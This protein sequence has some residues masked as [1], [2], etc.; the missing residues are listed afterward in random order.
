MKKVLLLLFVLVF[1]A[2]ILY[3]PALAKE[4]T[5]NE[6]KAEAEANRSAYNKAKEQKELSEKERNEAVAEKTRVEE[7]IGRIEIELK[8]IEKQ[9]EKIQ[10]DIEK[11][12]KQMKEIMSFVQVSNGESNYMEYIF[13]ATDFTD[14]IYRVSVAEQLEDYNKKLID[15]YNENIKKLNTKQTELNNKTAELNKKREELS[16]LEAKLI[17][18]IE[19]LSEGMLDKDREYKTTIDLVNS[20]T[21]NNCYGTDTLSQCLARKNAAIQNASSWSAKGVTVPSTNG[22]YMPISRGRVTSDF[23]WRGDEFHNGIDISNG[24]YGDNV[25]PIAVGQVILVQSPNTYRENGRNCGNWIVYVQHNINGH[26][27]IT[28]YWHLASPSVSNGQNV[29]PN[30]PIGKMGGLHSVD[31]CAYGVH[32]HLNLFDGNSW[33]I[34]WPNSGRINP[35]IVMPQMPSQGVYFTR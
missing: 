18:E 11:K 14:F 2:V 30:T 33:N 6:L 20:L 35:R 12:D 24:V 8:E 13:G 34:R 32:V 15:E 22:T 7:E 21:S 9:I 25:Y 28:S 5:L 17:K 19:E 1:T 31:E 29:N 23:G 26:I 10:K 16:I 3:E 27:Y 4:K